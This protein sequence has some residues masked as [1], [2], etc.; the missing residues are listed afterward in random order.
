MRTLV[1]AL[2]IALGAEIASAQL[3]AKQ[4]T[5]ADTNLLFGG[6]DAEGGIGDWYV[7]N[8]VVQAVIDDAGPVPDLVPILAP[9]DVPP[10]QSEISPTGGTI[11]DLGP[12]GQ[13]GDELPQLF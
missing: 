11:I 4:I 2:L 5:A 7:S 10:M 6:A 1:G 3:V 8:G 13:D 9:A 12:A